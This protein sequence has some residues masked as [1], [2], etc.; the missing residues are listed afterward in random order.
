MIK[1]SKVINSIKIISLVAI[2]ILMSLLIIKEKNHRNI[3]GID[4]EPS[5]PNNSLLAFNTPYEEYD[6]TK[7]DENT[8][9]VFMYSILSEEITEK[10][11]GVSWRENTPVKLDELSYIKVTYW[12]FDDNECM[13]EMVVHKKLAQEVIDIFKELYDKKFPIGKIRLIDDYDANDELS[14]AD[15]NTSAFCSREVTG[16]KEV[17]SNHSYGIAIDINPIQN[18]YVKGDIVL[19]EEG[20]MYLDRGNVR[21][22]MITRDDTCYNAFKSRGWTWGGEWNGLKDYQHFEKDI[23]ITR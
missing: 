3:Q 8:A 12:G 15:N 9:P 2:V 18:P 6:D 10:I 17:F 4:E 21:K 19:P 23:E 16:K 14:M 20:S 7:N 22:G 5:L 13:G 1:S 11:V